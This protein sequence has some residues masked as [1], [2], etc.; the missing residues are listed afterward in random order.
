MMDVVSEVKASFVLVVEV[1]RLSLGGVVGLCLLAVKDMRDTNGGG[2]VF[3]FTTTGE[4]WRMVV[5]D[6]NRFEM[7]ERF[8]ILFDTMDE[9]RER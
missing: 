9:Q 3:G 8:T 5:C 4:D 1:K 7:T 2:K 6:G